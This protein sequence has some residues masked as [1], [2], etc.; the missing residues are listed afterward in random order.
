M[1]T[2]DA[3]ADDFD[4][5]LV[6]LDGVVYVGPAEIPGAGET[7]SQLT[8]SGRRV[9]FV[10]NNASRTPQEVADH[11]TS[12]SVPATPADV[13]TSAQAGAALIARQVP[14]GSAVLAVGGP[15]WQRP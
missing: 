11:L 15:G 2:T 9:C 10:T 4:S 3:L 6:D 7:L 14:A 8:A 1:I 12:L 5:F 13:L